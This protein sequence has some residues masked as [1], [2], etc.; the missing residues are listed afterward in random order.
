MTFPDGNA[1]ACPPAKGFG[2][3]GVDAL[4]MVEAARR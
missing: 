1:P 4:W 2:D 3:C